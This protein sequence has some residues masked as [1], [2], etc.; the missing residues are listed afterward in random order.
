MKEVTFDRHARRRMKWRRISEQ[1]V[2]LVLASPEKTEPTVHG[3]TNA[4]LHTAGRYLKVTFKE[5]ENQIFI[6]S[7][8]DKHD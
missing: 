4:Y 3:R 2:K 6:I 1:E 7:V 5:T 8:V